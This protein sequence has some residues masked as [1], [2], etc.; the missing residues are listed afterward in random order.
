ML[1]HIQWIPFVIGIIIGVIG[2]VYGK[3]EHPIIY[4]YPNPKTAKTTIYK[5]KNGMCYRYVPNQVDCDKNEEKLKDF[6]LN[7]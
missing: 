6:P 4:S 2:V 5:D 1:N 7:K 3:S